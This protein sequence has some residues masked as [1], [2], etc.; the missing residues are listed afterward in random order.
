ME[1]VPEPAG[2]LT[3]PGQ[4][5]SSSLVLTKFLSDE[6]LERSQSFRLI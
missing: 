5:P 2:L 1:H 3:C 6:L 4:A